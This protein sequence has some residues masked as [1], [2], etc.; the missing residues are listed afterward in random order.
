MVSPD[1][2][3]KSEDYAMCEMTLGGKILRRL[4]VSTIMA[5]LAVGVVLRDIA[6]WAVALVQAGVTLGLYIGPL[7]KAA[8]RF[9]SDLLMMPVR[10][11]V[12]LLLLFGVGTTWV[13][14]VFPEVVEFVKNDLPL[15]K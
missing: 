3:G 13:E 8:E 1:F 7:M 10:W 9:M 14:E 5:L 4:K 15:L 2:I 11:I 6:L 12:A